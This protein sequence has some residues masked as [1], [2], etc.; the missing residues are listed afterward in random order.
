MVEFDLKINPE[1]RTSYWRRQLV[2]AFGTELKLLPNQEAGVIYRK[3]TDPRRVLASLDVIRQDLQLRVN[4]K[5]NGLTPN[6][7]NRG[8]HSTRASSDGGR[9]RTATPKGRTRGG[10][11][12]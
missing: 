5:R 7:K 6:S 12:E 10:D 8:R 4:D 11:P 2:D 3:G 9:P 1:Q